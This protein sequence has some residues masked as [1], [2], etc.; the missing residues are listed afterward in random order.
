LE[1]T[2]EASFYVNTSDTVIAK[3]GSYVSNTCDNDDND[4]FWNIP[5]VIGIKKKK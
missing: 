1:D 3:Y 4:H 2:P 5:N